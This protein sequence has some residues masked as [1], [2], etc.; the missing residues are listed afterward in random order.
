MKVIEA[1]QSTKVNEESSLVNDL[2]PYHVEFGDVTVYHEM[3]D[4]TSVKLNLIEQI[5]QQLNQLELMN[6]KRQFLMK[7]ILQVVVD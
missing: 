1:F 3:G 7:E 2:S 4:Q 5:H 6:S